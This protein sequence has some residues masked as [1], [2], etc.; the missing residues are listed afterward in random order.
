MNGEE[1]FINSATRKNVDK[2]V[3]Y[4]LDLCHRNIY[5]STRKLAFTFK[6]QEEIQMENLITGMKS[7][8]H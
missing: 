1:I 4:F 7:F 6:E 8:L 3:S 2:F 5:L